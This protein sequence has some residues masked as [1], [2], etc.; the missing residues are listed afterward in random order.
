[1]DQAIKD[2][3]AALMADPQVADVG[4]AAVDSHCDEVTS[5]RAMTPKG[6]RESA[7]TIYRTMMKRLPEN[8]RQELHALRDEARAKGYVLTEE[9]VKEALGPSGVRVIENQAYHCLTKSLFP[10]DR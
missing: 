10:R 7:A 6:R 5:L 8:A 1:M 4:R 2:K 3:L 9:N